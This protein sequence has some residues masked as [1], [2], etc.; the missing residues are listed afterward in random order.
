VDVHHYSSHDDSEE[1]KTRECA[2]CKGKGT[3]KDPITGSLSNC[4]VCGGKGRN[5]FSGTVEVCGKCGGT[6]IGG[7]GLLMN[8]P[9]K[10]DVCQGKGFNQF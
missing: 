1:V 6:G 2:R 4:D 7:K 8:K 9:R 5:S 3:L 10:C